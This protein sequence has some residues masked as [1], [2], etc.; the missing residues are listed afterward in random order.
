MFFKLFV[1]I[2]STIVFILELFIKFDIIVDQLN[3]YKIIINT[4]V[5][6]ILYYIMTIHFLNR[7]YIFN[8]SI[9]EHL[10]K[11]KKYDKIAS[12][13]ARKFLSEILLK[14]MNFK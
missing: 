7:E 2:F 5:Y 4:L 12:V 11:F 6:T 3:K 9:K 14:H 8:K 1:D 10:L 13:Y